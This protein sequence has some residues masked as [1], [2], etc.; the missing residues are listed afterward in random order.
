MDPTK[1]ADNFYNSGYDVVISGID[2]TEALVEAGKA[3]KAGKKALALPYDYKDGCAEAPDVCLGVPYFNWGPEYVKTLQMVQAGKWS[4][5]FRWVGP[6]WS[7]ID[8][9][10]TSIVGFNKGKALSADNSTK[11]DTF[12]KGLGDGSINLYKGPINFQD[13]S[14][15]LKDGETATDLQIWYLPQLLKG[16]EGSSK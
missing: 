1:E 10:D 15:F 8:N 13:G 12:I 6:D 14:V 16:M 5:F 3:A 4:Q 9:P 2:T 11:L 7:N